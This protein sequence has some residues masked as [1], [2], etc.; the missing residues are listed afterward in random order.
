MTIQWLEEAQ[1][2]FCQGAGFYEEQ[3][4]DLGERFI[5]RVES[6][7]TRILAAPLMPRCFFEQCRKVRVE[8]F[9][10]ALIY[11][12]DEQSIKIIALAHAKRHPDYWKDRQ[13][14]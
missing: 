1:E 9:P 5:A 2:E 4:E 11:T 10:Y 8:K 13:V 7:I 12:I 3:V 14:K 6:A